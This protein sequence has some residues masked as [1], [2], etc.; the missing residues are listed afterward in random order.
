MWG[1]AAVALVA[2]VLTVASMSPYYL[3]FV[4]PCALMMGAM[5]CM[6][7]GASGSGG[8]RRGGER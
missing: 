3:L 1:C 5:V 8:S 4:V 6:M 2:I 7:M